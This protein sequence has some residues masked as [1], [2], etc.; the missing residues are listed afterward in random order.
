MLAGI[1]FYSLK[2]INDTYFSCNKYILKGKVERIETRQRVCMCVNHNIRVNFADIAVRYG[3]HMNLL[4]IYMNPSL[5]PSHFTLLRY[6]YGA[7]VNEPYS[8]WEV[9]TGYGSGLPNQLHGAL[10]WSRMHIA[11]RNTLLTRAFILVYIEY[12][13]EKG[14]FKLLKRFIKLIHDYMR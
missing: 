8:P 9:E 1:I 14:F 7:L 4:Y 11:I 12:L 3:M 6:T 13:T 10:V 5:A 2:S